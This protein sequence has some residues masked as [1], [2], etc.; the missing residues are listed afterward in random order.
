MTNDFGTMNEKIPS[1]AYIMETIVEVVSL[2][3]QFAMAALPALIERVG[4]KN[5]TLKTMSDV[6][7]SSY[8]IAD[9]M[10]AVRK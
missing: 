1:Q 10:L 6:T 8:E 9:A 5:T 7:R 2:R 3:D 4:R